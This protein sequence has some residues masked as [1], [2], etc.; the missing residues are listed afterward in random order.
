MERMSKTKL[1]MAIVGHGFVGAAVDYGFPDANCDKIII[2]PKYGSSVED[3]D[4]NDIQVSF[5]CVPTPMGADASIDASI[6]IRTVN[7]LLLH[8]DG[9]VVIKSTVIPSIVHALAK[10]ERVIYNPE[11]LTEKS[12]NEDFVNPPMHVFGGNL[13][14]TKILEKLYETYSACKACP[15]YHMTAAE[16]SFVKY[17]MN[18]FLA[19]KVLFFNQFYDIVDEFGGNYNVIRNAIGTDPRIG[20][21]HTMVPGHDGR[22]SFGGSCFVKDTAALVMFARDQKVPFTVL[23]EVVRRNQD[24]RNSYKEPLEREKQMHVRFDYDI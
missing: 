12:A 20:H 16:A 10:D 6:L 18:S 8:T 4:G 13:E 23:E 15:V 5:V 1:K 9:L 11:F 3:L 22:R 17:G 19:S 21:S 2:D 24:Y 7:L 14:K